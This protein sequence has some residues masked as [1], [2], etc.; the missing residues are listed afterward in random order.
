MGLQ[1]NPLLDRSSMKEQCSATA[2][3]LVSACEPRGCTCKDPS[4]SPALMSNL[5]LF[6]VEDPQNSLPVPRRKNP[7]LD[8][9]QSSLIVDGLGKVG[10]SQVA[11]VTIRFLPKLLLRLT[12]A[13]LHGRQTLL[14]FCFNQSSENLD[15]V[16]VRLITTHRNTTRYQPR[17]YTNP[18]NQFQYPVFPTF[19]P[20]R[21]TRNSSVMGTSP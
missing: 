21:N 7:F 5:K 3:A 9:P 11:V 10:W 12:N 15:T 16:A 4:V 6:C 8:V 14:F 18:C 1:R 17:N 20:I 2:T 19:R 13:R